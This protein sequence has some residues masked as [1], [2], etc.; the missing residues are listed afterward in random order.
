MTKA[1]RAYLSRV[2]E[3]GCIVCREQFGVWSPAEIH[4]A[5]EHTGA[6]RRESHAFA[7]GLCPLHHRL[8]NWGEAYH[9][10]PL[11][12]ERRYGAQREMVQ[13]TQQ[14]AGYGSR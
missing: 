11:E 9:A 6:G 12:W 5:R 7:I 1:D 3:L 4:H 10:G 2:S 13:R 14:E 8:G